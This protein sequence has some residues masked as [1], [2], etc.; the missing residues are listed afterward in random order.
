VSRSSEDTRKVISAFRVA[1]AQALAAGENAE[2]ASAE[3][4]AG[5]LER[6]LDNR[7][8]VERMRALTIRAES[9]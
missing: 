5:R 3:R 4:Q 9:K 7:E 8:A 1:A 2:A 6:E